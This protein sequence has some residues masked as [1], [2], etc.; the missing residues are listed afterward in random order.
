MIRRALWYGFWF[1]IVVFIAKNPSQAAAGAGG[2]LRGAYSLA[3]GFGSF[4]SELAK[5]AG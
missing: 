1:F 2:L 4:V 5:H 3:S